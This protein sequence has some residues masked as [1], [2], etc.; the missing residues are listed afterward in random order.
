VRAGRALLASVLI[1]GLAACSTAPGPRPQEQSAPGP[2]SPASASSGGS[3]VLEQGRA[4]WY[5]LAFHGRRTANGEKF[6]MNALTAAH[7]SLPFGTRVLVRNPSNGRSVIVRINDRGPYT[8]GR[9]IDLSFAAARALG[10]V[11]FGT[12]NVVLMTAPEDT[13]PAA[14]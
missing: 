11:T 10:I 9:I 6:D 1:A 2:D 14:R 5:G 3:V 7:P 12:K 13:R 4:S 8:G